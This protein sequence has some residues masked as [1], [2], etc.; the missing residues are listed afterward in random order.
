M[1]SLLV[2]DDEPNILYAIE[3]AFRS[4]SLTVLTAQTGKEG[5]EL[6]RLRRPDALILDVRLSDM[7]G[8]DV[9]NE[10]RQIDPQLPVIMITA[11]GT[12]ETTIE[13]MKRGAVDYLLKP[14]DLPELREVVRKA[15]ELRRLRSVPAVMPGDRPDESADQI[16]G[17]SAVMQEVCKAIG[18]VA[19][20][21]VT[22]LITG[23][24]GTGK[25]LVVRALYQHSQQSAGPF[26]ALN[27]A[28]IPQALLESEL[29]GHERG[30]FTGADH[31]RIGKFEQAHQG[32]LFLDEIGDMCPAT[33]A[34]VLRVLQ[35]QRFERVGGNETIQT[36]V[37]LIAATNKDL[38]AE[39]AAGRFRGDLYYRLN[40]FTIHLPPLR[41]R[42]E[43]IPLLA[44]YFLHR[45]NRGLNPMVQS[46]HPD[47]MRCLETY[48]WPGNVRQLQSV[49]KY[50]L[51][52]SSSDVLLL[53]SLP[54]NLRSGEAPVILPTGTAAGTLDV[55]SLTNNLLAAGEARR[56]S[57]RLSGNG[58]R[59]ARGG[60]AA[61]QGQPGRGQQDPGHFPND[62]S[63]QDPRAGHGRGETGHAG[64]GNLGLSWRAA[65]RQA[66]WFILRQAGKIS[67]IRLH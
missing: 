2:V 63:F 32:T 4:E 24:S 50:A 27:C 18:R 36:K 60:H 41:Q 54:E 22:V 26:L 29:F 51:I 55:A 59:R 35:E 62:A 30:A 1:P 11:F 37:R 39:V 56:L 58:P 49:I 15:L 42:R 8:M 44:D 14:L 13:A 34:K 31:R 47:T 43:D 64:A 16:V 6:I 5:L 38:N 7:S 3:K 53:E 40:V 12:T 23:E 33:Q 17:R 52:K 66:P 25:E 20:L 48:A 19:P 65:G 61:R 46:I 9:F 21:D 57:P 45:F 28:A 10:A 67:S